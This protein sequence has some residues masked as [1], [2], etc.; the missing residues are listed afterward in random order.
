MLVIRF[1]G[2]RHTGQYF[3]V[4]QPGMDIYFLNL[5]KKPVTAAIVDTF[6]GETNPVTP[7]GKQIC[8]S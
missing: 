3:R 7:S 2:I 1:K 5:R 8:I 4:F 6:G